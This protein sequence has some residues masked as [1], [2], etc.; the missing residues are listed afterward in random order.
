MDRKV[1]ILKN[2]KGIIDTT[3]REGMQFRSVDFTLSQQK[4]IFW[5]LS[6]IGVERIEVG[7]PIS[8]DVLKTIKTLSSLKAPQKLLCHVRNRKEDVL[9]ALSLPVVGVN[10]LCTV[11]SERIKSMN[12]TV[13]D[14]FFSLSKHVRMAKSKGKEVRVSV[15]DFFGQDNRLAMKVYTLADQLGV[16]RIGVADTLG[17]AMPWEVEEK[18]EFLRK[19]VSADI[20][21]HLHNDLG[22]A[23]A[24]A[25]SA[26]LKGAN[27]IDTTILGIGERTGIT[28]LCLFLANLYMM[29]KKI[30][31]RYKMELLTKAEN[32][33]AKKSSIDVPFNI[34]TNK[35]NGFSHKA[36]IHINAL[37][38]HGPNKYELFP[39]SI[40][41]NKRKLIYGSKISGKTTKEQVQRFYKSYG[42]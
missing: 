25:M 37:I 15:E 30:V 21:V 39:P 17:K 19:R 42:R 38:K 41:G 5:F 36:G 4:K 11:D 33:V 28:P 29:D 40:I 8:D 12:K 3:L 10:I 1:K 9:R 20:E 31:N 14:Y 6:E 7:N 32:Y 35:I 22:Q 18:I 2:F 24:N 23:T 27:W 16:D 34:L 13:A 26:L